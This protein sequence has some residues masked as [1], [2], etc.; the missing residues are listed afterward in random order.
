M[1]F[2]LTSEQV[3]MVCNIYF[4]FYPKQQVDSLEDSQLLDAVDD[5]MMLNCIEL[6]PES[7]PSLKTYSMILMRWKIPVRQLYSL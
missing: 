4:I 5:E 2:V 7:P 1:T 3:I 6:A